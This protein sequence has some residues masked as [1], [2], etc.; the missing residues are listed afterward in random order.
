MLWVQFWGWPHTYS[1]DGYSLRFC[2][3]GSEDQISFSIIGCCGFQWIGP[4]VY[5]H[6]NLN[7]D[8]GH[9]LGSQRIRASLTAGV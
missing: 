4:L 2:W 8:H 3:D 5:V 6:L 9:V 1:V 7:S